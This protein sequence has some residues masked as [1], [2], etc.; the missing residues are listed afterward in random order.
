V[1]RATLRLATLL[2][3]VALVLVILIVGVASSR[4]NTARP[5]LTGTAS[6]VP[7]TSGAPAAATGKC[8]LG[9]RGADSRSP[10]DVSLTGQCSGDIVAAF[11]CVPQTD[12]L[13]FTARRALD[14]LHIFYLTIYLEGY[15]HP[16]AYTGAVAELQI[17]G[18][19]GV[20]SWTNHGFP[21]DVLPDGSL[22]FGSTALPAD[23]GTSSTGTVTISGR[24]VCAPVAAQP[25]PGTATTSTTA[26]PVLP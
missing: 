8:S 5:L 15:L 6:G 17:T 9:R 20:Q 14:T 22:R 4:T 23:L 3:L 26:V 25:A 19:S 1:S 11:S 2:S 18:P 7:T 24:A 10:T 13:Y 16:G 12:D 21:I